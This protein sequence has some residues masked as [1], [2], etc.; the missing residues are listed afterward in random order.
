V[1]KIKLKSVLISTIMFVILMSVAYAAPV[2]LVFTDVDVKVGGRTDKNLDDGDRIDR[3]AAPGDTVEFRIKVENNFTSAE[4]LKIEDITIEITIEEIDDG[5]DLDDESNDFDLRDGRDKRITIKFEIP[6]EVEEDDFEVIIIAQGEDENG[7]DHEIEMRLTLEVEKERHQLIITRKTLSPAE[8]TC[9]RN[10]IQLSTSL[11]NIGNEDEEDV[12]LQVLSR[13]IDVDIV[14]EIGELEAEPFEDESKFSDIFRFSVPEDTESGS[15]PVIIR[16]LYDNDR[17]KTEET[18]TLTVNDCLTNQDTTPNDE[19]EEDNEDAVV[20]ITSNNGNQ[21]TTGQ[22]TTTGQL[23]TGTVVS[24][25]SGFGSNAFIVGIIIAEVVA[26]I[27]G[28]VL[29]VSLFSRRR[30]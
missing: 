9:N 12:T 4:D 1:V 25:E 17:K 28:I 30:V 23:P 7:T 18:L 5:D 2:K 21:A 20:V 10:N 19:G 29:V 26:V 15:Y 22:V 13:D 11:L 6:L 24:Q 3:E 14:R 16:A 8:V 27:V